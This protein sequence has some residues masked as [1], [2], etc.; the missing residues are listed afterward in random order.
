MSEHFDDFI[1][2]FLQATSDV[3]SPDIFRLWSGIALVAG[4][5]E[6]RV[7]LRNMQ[8]PVYPNLYVLLVAPPGVGKSIIDKVRDLW[9][10]T[11]EPNSKIP[12]FKVAPDSMT[13]ASLVD[14]MAK[15]TRQ[16]IPKNGEAPLTYSS[17]LVAAEEFSVLLPAYDMEYIGTLN[18]IWNNKRVH[19][20]VRRH[21]Q[22]QKVLIENPQ[23]NMLGGAQPGWLASIFPEDAWST[24][25][26]RRLIMIYA[27]EAP[28]KDIW[29]EISP[30]HNL[31]NKLLQGLGKLSQVYG[32]LKIDLSAV[33]FLQAWDK[34][35]RLP[36][37]THSKLSFYN[38]SRYFQLIKLSI[39]SA[40]SRICY[41]FPVKEED[42]KVSRFD[43]ERAL[44]WLLQAE[45][46]MP[47]IFRAMVGK[48]DKD[49]IDE[50]HIF[51]T[52]AFARNKQ[53]AVSGEFIR[54]FLIERVPHDKI[55]SLIG[56]AE[57]ANLIARV[58][59]TQDMYIP[60]PRF[61]HKNIE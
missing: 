31:Q 19:E 5:L 21:G 15:S 11:T 35:G 60:R 27:S 52:A 54:Q 36:Q 38:S 4:A 57:R 25:I 50:M 12:A 40:M 24:G 44:E 48:S 33:E 2:D 43:V 9:S 56:T 26:G 18:A 30:N 34:G 6:R 3:L 41:F 51:V 20:E 7:W 42:Y 39:I 45:K 16:F 29:G 32:G 14:T 13:K 61:Q 23:L 22:H 58:G 28:W 55:E 47:D 49:V 17:L 46:L 53:K 1:S 8:G 59:G 37:P 10:D